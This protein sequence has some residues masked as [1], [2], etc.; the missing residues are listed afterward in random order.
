MHFLY[1]TIKV[2]ITTKHPLLIIQIQFSNQSTLIEIVKINGRRS[3]CALSIKYQGLTPKY[4]ACQHNTVKT[5][6]HEQNKTTDWKSIKTHYLTMYQT[7][8]NQRKARCTLGIE[9]SRTVAIREIQFESA[10][11]ELKREYLRSSALSIFLVSRILPL[12]QT[13]QHKNHRVSEDKMY[14]EQEEA[15]YTVQI[16]EGIIETHKATQFCALDKNLN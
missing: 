11:S 2:F 15:L 3:A 12:S 13:E 10:I 14:I 6:A 4:K 1:S 5:I 8:E 7:K 9:N 16:I